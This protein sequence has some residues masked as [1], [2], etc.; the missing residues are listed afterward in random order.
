[1]INEKAEVDL[2]ES[3]D[4]VIHRNN[5]KKVSRFVFRP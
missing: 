2:P 5:F 4:K 3:N 1:M